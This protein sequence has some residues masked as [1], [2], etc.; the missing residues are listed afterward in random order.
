[1]HGKNIAHG[2]GPDMVKINNIIVQYTY[3][4]R[5]LTLLNSSCNSSNKHGNGKADE[6]FTEI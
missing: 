5:S 4:F 6:I 1:M 2:S 3:V